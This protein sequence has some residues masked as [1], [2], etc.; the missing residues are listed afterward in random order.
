MRN[1]ALRQ[2]PATAANTVDDA[3]MFG[4][5][6]ESAY[7][8]QGKVLRICAWCQRIPL[9]Q[10]FW[11]DIGKAEQLLPFLTIAMLEEATHGV[12]PDCY[13]TFLS[14]IQAVPV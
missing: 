1:V 4:P 8:Q 14:G 7:R 11:V 6:H 10:D 2:A 3:R 13:H 12:C 5:A 9:R